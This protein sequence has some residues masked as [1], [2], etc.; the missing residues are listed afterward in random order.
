MKKKITILLAFIMILCISIIAFAED[1]SVVDSVIE[2]FQ[3]LSTEELEELDGKLHD[4]IAAN[5]NELTSTNE[6]S[7]WVLKYYV[8][9]FKNPTNEAYI[10]NVNMIQGTFSNAVTTDS[11]L[12][13]RFLIED[14]FTFCL[15]EYGS[16]LVK[17]GSY[18]GVDYDILMLDT[19][20]NKIPLVGTMHKNGD[21]IIITKDYKEAFIE[22][23][24]KDG[25]ISMKVTEKERPTTS[26]LFTFSTVGFG[27]LYNENFEIK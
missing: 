1:T 4:A 10:G 18:T 14:Y 22:A 20:G 3:Y 21:R 8:D 27:K 26:Y 19:E 24:K 6:E 13:V 12:Q 11:K 9:E 23:L 7:N 17:A 25:T 15:Y 16:N 2:L 5:K